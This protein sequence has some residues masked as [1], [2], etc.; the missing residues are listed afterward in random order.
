MVNIL[1]EVFRA[2]TISG[3]HNNK[4]ECNEPLDEMRNARISIN[5]AS[6]ECFWNMQQNDR[7]FLLWP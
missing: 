1:M 3:C 4:G 7:S 2:L 6:G 5:F